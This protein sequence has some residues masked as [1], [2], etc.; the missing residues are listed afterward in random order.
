MIEPKSTFRGKLLTWVY[1]PAPVVALLILAVAKPELSIF[2]R[3]TGVV[4]FYVVLGLCGLYLRRRERGE[5]RQRRRQDA[6]D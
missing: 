3:L 2:R 5:R 1:I 4:T 6:E